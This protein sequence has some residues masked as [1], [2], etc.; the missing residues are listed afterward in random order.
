MKKIIL[1]TICFAT[2]CL[3]S[4]SHE[5]SISTENKAVEGNYS[6][7]K[8]KEQSLETTL[9]LPAQLNPYEEVAIYPRITGYVKSIS[10][11]IGTEVKQG[12]TLMELEAP[13]VE[14]NTIVAH[15]KYIKAQSAYNASRDGYSRLLKTAETK[16]A[17]SQGDLQAAQSKMQ[18]DSAMSNSEKAGWMAMESM[19]NYLVVKAPFAGTITQRNIDPGA[20]VVVGNKNEMKPMLQLQEI[21]KLRL[22]VSVP[23]TF[24][25]QL[26]S[27]QKILFTV[28]ALPG[29][30]FSGIL[31]RKANSLDPKFRSEVVEVDVTNTDNILMAGM[32]AE[33]L[34]P[35][36]GHTNACI[37]PQSA[38]VTSTEKKYVI[39]VENNKTM[40]VNVVTGNENKGMIEI[41]GDIKTGDSIIEKGSEDTKQNEAVKEE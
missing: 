11:D 13:D 27:N 18:S 16:G 8:I 26:Q 22:Q 36:N 32:Y 38:V 31:S 40:L 7:F 24:A 10:V 34:L 19:K 4:C 2:V 15:E 25:T 39:K 12:E 33:V 1:I 23:E 9:R 28:E 41:F 37:V 17:V 20:L 21:S 35:L 14:Q 5:Q 6:L 3:V 29:K 30:E